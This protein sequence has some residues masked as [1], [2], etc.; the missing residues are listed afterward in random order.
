MLLSLG[1]IAQDNSHVPFVTFKNHEQSIVLSPSNQKN[2][3]NSNIGF[4]F[5]LN[6]KIIV[7][8][9]KNQKTVLDSL[10][11]LGKVQ[12]LAELHDSE[13]ILISPI[14]AS[15]TK[16]YKLIENLPN[17]MAVQPDF[18]IVR[19]AKKMVNND[20][21]NTEKLDI[22]RLQT[23]QCGIKPT[24]KRIAIIDDGFDLS[25]PHFSVFKVLLDY[26]ADRQQAM[27]NRQSNV[28]G[29][30]NMVAGVIANQL[31]SKYSTDEQAVAELVAIRQASTLNS[32]MILAFSVSQKMK[33]DVINSSWTLPFVSQLLADV[34]RDGLDYGGVSY[35]VVSAGNHAEDACV[36]NKLSEIEGV[37]TVGALSQDGT[38]ASYS[39]YGRCV[40]LYA[41]A[42]F[43]PQKHRTHIVQS[44]TSSAAAMVT[45]EISYL[46]GCGLSSSE[47]GLKNKN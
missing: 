31:L 3:Y 12:V 6:G 37:T 7:Q 39:N 14:S 20:T 46:L 21:E 36:A 33:V 23:A 18:A 26:D 22:E 25:K 4:Q 15:F 9:P 13:V 29:H 42:N 44:G 10:K 38:M 27:F 40:D 19:A 28:R 47:I 11:K 8:A 5:Y 17:M 32:A 34:I 24:T 43:L 30:G 35:V 1:V 2:I 45:G 16:S 41:P